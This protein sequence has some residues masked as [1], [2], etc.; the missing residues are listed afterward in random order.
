MNYTIIKT[1][2]NFEK[3]VGKI[4]FKFNGWES[5]QNESYEIEHNLNKF[6]YIKFAGDFIY[7][8]NLVIDY[9]EF[10]NYKDYVESLD[11]LLK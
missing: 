10:D 11:K 4:Y 1:K 9:I 8:N 6:G 2:F 5:Y 3:K 7:S